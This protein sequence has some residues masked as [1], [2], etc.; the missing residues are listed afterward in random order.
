MSS[1]IFGSQLERAAF[2]LGLL[3]LAPWLIF[4][5]IPAIYY[6]HGLSD[7]LQRSI[8][9]PINIWSADKYQSKV[10]W[11][12]WT[13]LPGVIVCASAIVWPFIGQRVVNWIR[14]GRAS[15]GKPDSIDTSPKFRGTTIRLAKRVGV[16]FGNA[17]R[18]PY[19]IL[20]L[21]LLTCS[22]ALV[23]LDYRASQFVPSYDGASFAGRLAFASIRYFVDVLL[24]VLLVCALVYGRLRGAWVWGK[25][26]SAQAV[27]APLWSILTPFIIFLLLGAKFTYETYNEL[28][29]NCV[30]WAS[31]QL[32]TPSALVGFLF[33][34]RDR[35][36]S[37]ERQAALVVELREVANEMNK[38][39]PS[40]MPNGAGRMLK[41]EAVGTTLRYVVRA[42]GADDARATP[43]IRNELKP[44][45]VDHVCNSAVGEAM[46]RYRFR[47]EYQFIGLDGGEIAMIGITRANCGPGGVN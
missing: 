24:L 12:D 20:G 11:Y 16:W 10:E 43:R 40:D 29:S 28:R 7:W 2:V 6:A 14:Y 19:F 47:I 4:R 32:C 15:Q 37:E 18:N 46:A 33:H 9:D 27:E 30:A 38:G 22:F 3:G 21:V 35:P 45:V 44:R 1:R 34:L 23:F 31:K 17:A 8:I 41:V 5:A 25:R 26:A 42:N 13:L 39:L 36:S